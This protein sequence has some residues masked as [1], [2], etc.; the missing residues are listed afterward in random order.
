MND[1]RCENCME[2]HTTCI[3]A[4]VDKFF[5]EGYEYADEEKEP[6]ADAND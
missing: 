3:C 2:L 6:D 1:R 4:M 5:G